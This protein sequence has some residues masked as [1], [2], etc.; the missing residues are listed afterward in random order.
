LD[1]EVSLYLEAMSLQLT[2]K[3]DRYF[4]VSAIHRKKVYLKTQLSSELQAFLTFVDRQRS[5]QRRALWCY[6]ERYRF[7]HWKQL[8]PFNQNPGLL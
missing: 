7:C 1:I 8:P 6:E 2:P 4:K 3:A 5:K